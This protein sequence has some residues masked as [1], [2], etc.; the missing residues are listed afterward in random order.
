MS[1][2]YGSHAAFKAMLLS[3]LEHHRIMCS[4]MDSD[5]I[6]DS[7]DDGYYNSTGEV[8]GV[9]YDRGGKQLTGFKLDE[10]DGVAYVSWDNPS[11]GPGATIPDADVAVIHDADNDGVILGC[12]KFDTRSVKDGTFF[13]EMP[14]H[15]PTTA[16]IRVR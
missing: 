15:S 8:S 5:M 16:L 10:A 13:L 7:L 3:S 9:G 11:W 6:G 1:I 12:F 4:L 2:S 14:E